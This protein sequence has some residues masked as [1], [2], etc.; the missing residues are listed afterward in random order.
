[1]NIGIKR[2]SIL[3]TI[4]V[5]V[6]ALIVVMRMLMFRW[7]SYE[8]FDT[9]ENFTSEEALQNIADLYSKENMTV[10]NLTVTKTLDIKDKLNFKGEELIPKGIIVA[11]TGSKAPPGWTLC[12]GKNGT[13][14]LKGR[15]IYGHGAGDKMNSKGGS[16]THIL[17][18]EEIASHNHR[19]GGISVRGRPDGGDDFGGGDNGKGFHYVTTH[20]ERDGWKK[21]EDSLPTDKRGSNKEHN[22][23][24]P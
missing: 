3:F 13:P 22:N 15:F 6:F 2:I 10:S 20:Y 11:W 7:C 5:A 16:K 21:G 23:M 18:E 19:T 17:T 24:P 8:G 14:G 9:I 4:F 12:D 1:M